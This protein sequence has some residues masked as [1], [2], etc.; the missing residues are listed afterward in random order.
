[1]LLVETDDNELSGTIPTEIGL[2]ENLN[3]LNLGKFWY[4]FDNKCIFAE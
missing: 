1:M 2:L 4:I 3:E